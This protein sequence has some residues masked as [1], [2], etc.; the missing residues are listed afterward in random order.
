MADVL[1]RLAQ[2]PVVVAPMAGGP[3]TAGLVLAATAAGALGF[4]AAGYKTAAA[5]LA[6]MDEVQAG[7]GAPFGV[8]V[9]VPGPPTDRAALEGYLA[10]LERDAAAL[11][12]APA[13]RRVPT[14]G[15]SPP[16]ATPAR[17]ARRCGGCL[18]TSRRSPASRWSPRGRS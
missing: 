13:R 14:A 7:P 17:P 5:M 10:E 1:D 15:P 11:G 8:N 6:E 9:F 16:L 3:S 12:V 4:L 18:P 2:C